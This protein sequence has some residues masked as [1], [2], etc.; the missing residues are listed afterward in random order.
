MGRREETLSDSNDLEIQSAYEELRREL[1]E[2]EEGNATQEKKI[3]QKKAKGDEIYSQVKEE[4]KNAKREKRERR[5]LTEERRKSLVKI[6][7][8]F[9]EAVK[10]NIIDLPKP[11]KS[12]LIG[13]Q[14]NLSD[15]TLADL[16]EYLGEYLIGEK[17]I[18]TEGKL[19]ENFKKKIIELSQQNIAAVELVLNQ[20]F[21]NKDKFNIEEDELKD[22]I[23]EISRTRAE[24][25]ERSSIGGYNPIDYFYKILNEEQTKFFDSLRSPEEFVQYISYLYQKLYKKSEEDPNFRSLSDEQKQKIIAQK[26]GRE[27]RKVAA[28]IIFTIY[29]KIIHHPN[30]EFRE[31]ENEGPWLQT[32]RDFYG[33]FMKRIEDLQH[34]LSSFS[35]ETTSRFQSLKISIPKIEVISGEVDPYT[36][37][38][39]PSFFVYTGEEK[40]LDISK[41]EDLFYLADLLHGFTV[42]EKRR[43]MYGHN[44]PYLLKNATSIPEVQ[45]KGLFKVIAN[46]ASQ[47][48]SSDLDEIFLDIEDAALIQHAMLMFEVSFEHRMIRED[49]IKNPLLLVKYFEEL[50][51]YE[52]KIF[53]DL[54]TRNPHLEEWELLRILMNAKII[55]LGTNYQLLHYFSYADPHLTRKGEPT[56]TGAGE[57]LYSVYDPGMIQKRFQDPSLTGGGV[58]W[59]PF[60]VFLSKFDH[61]Q[62]E[63]FK[64]AFFQS[65]IRGRAAFF[66]L[67]PEDW[68]IVRLGVDPGNVTQAG[69]FAYLDRWRVFHTY[70]SAWLR[71][72][73]NPLDQSLLVK[74]GSEVLVTA[75]KRL[76]NIGIDALRNFYIVKYLVPKIVSSS[77]EI[78]L[79]YKTNFLEL[80]RYFYR[81]YYSQKIYDLEIGK[82]FLPEGIDSEEKFIQYVEKRLDTKEYH[83]SEIRDFLRKIFFDVATIMLIERLPSKVVTLEKTRFTQNGVRLFDEIRKVFEEKGYTREE[84]N[85]AFSD[86]SYV[87]AEFRQ[88]TVQKMREVFEKRGNLYGDISLDHSEVEY[89]LTPEKI[90]E[91]LQKHFSL[92]NLSSSEIN[93]R[94]EA[95]IFLHKNIIER[96]MSKPPDAFWYKEAQE[97]GFPLSEFKKQLVSRLEWFSKMWRTDEF[98]FS[99]TASELA[100]HFISFSANGPELLQRLASFNYDVAEVVYKN[101]AGPFTAA[102]RAD[103]ASFSLTNTY[104]LI[105]SIFLA[106]RG[107]WGTG[108][109]A[110]KI[111]HIFMRRAITYFR[112]DDGWSPIQRRIKNLF[113]TKPRSSSFSMED[114]G[115]PFMGEAYEFGPNELTKIMYDTI[116]GRGEIY[117]DQDPQEIIIRRRKLGRIS[118]VIGWL[119]ERLPFF[120]PIAEKEIKTRDFAREISGRSLMYMGGFSWEKFIRLDIAPGLIIALIILLFILGKKA[121]EKD[122]IIGGK[123]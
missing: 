59:M 42:S 13:I 47:I 62:A 116:G 32:P 86:L 115:G 49:W 60:N 75:W 36:G 61:T 66:E 78:D 35:E 82:V 68:Q 120:K 58:D 63:K 24:S 92:L 102:L 70:Y 21:L 94:I 108:F 122:F 85:Q 9:L 90:R 99:F 56:A 109:D 40:I 37:T 28:S 110:S 27:L 15:R 20:I 12:F 121:A 4:I 23:L 119:G 123:Q 112:R 101:W 91:I 34:S 39:I 1:K 64:N 2:I 105:D 33:V 84:Y 103:A 16:V 53:E 81:R 74:E 83:P 41:K 31:I 18:V 52:K 51:E 14:N 76:E 45:E 17:E 117:F 73:S 6:F 55:F 25:K 46:F 114:S 48:K 77:G 44:F 69:G 38:E 65:L 118:K 10:Q 113:L 57:F 95:V 5:V 88:L 43:L 54:R 22:L 96:A 93:R 80:S 87:E 107:Q 72:L 111:A 104:K 89:V 29:R 100:Y 79:D 67:L 50:P 106:S 26:I 97:K 11:L 30:E 71:D 8:K 98:G 7:G 3:I 19:D